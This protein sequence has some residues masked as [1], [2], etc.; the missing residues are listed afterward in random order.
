MLRA[1][2][3]PAPISLYTRHLP[4]HGLVYTRHLSLHGL[5]TRLASL[6]VLRGLLQLFWRR[7]GGCVPYTGILIISS[8]MCTVWVDHL[9]Y[10]D[11][12]G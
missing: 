12:C 11:A 1:Y 5:E 3:T 2:A 10:T 7:A 8:R 4:L 9:A 6:Q